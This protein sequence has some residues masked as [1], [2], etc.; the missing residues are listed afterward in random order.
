MKVL[1]D[2]NIEINAITHKTVMVPQVVRWGPHNQT[3][4]V[5]Q[6]VHFPPEGAFRIEQ[7]PYL[8]ALGIFAKD[9]K[10]EFFTSFEIR[11]EEFRQKGRCEGYL[12]INLLRSVPMKYVPCPTERSLMIAPSGSIGTTEEE[13]MDFFRS[14][15]CPRFL[16]IRKATGDAH[17]DDAYHLWT[18]EEAA[19]DGFLTMDKAFRNVVD[20]ERKAINSTVLVMTP[21]ELGEHLGLQPV[22]IERLA[23]EINPFS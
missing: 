2:R 18:A 10:L 19:L 22:E 13:Q 8:A 16:Q 23:E 1:V 6:R 9:A 17:V 11:M 5:A 20:H 14:I 12:G 21:K 15:R 7:L 3:R 4:P